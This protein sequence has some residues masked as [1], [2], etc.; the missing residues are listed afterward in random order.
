MFT[1]KDEEQIIQYLKSN[2]TQISGKYL[3]TCLHPSSGRQWAFTKEARG[4]CPPALLYW[5]SYS[6]SLGTVFI[7]PN[8]KFPDRLGGGSGERLQD[9]S[10]QQPRHGIGCCATQISTQ[11]SSFPG[12]LACFITDGHGIK[13]RT[14][15]WESP[16]WGP[17][18]F[19]LLPFLD[20]FCDAAS[21]CASLPASPDS[22]S[23]SVQTPLPPVFKGPLLS[24]W[25]TGSI[26]TFSC[27]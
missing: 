26:T 12:L 24:R 21:S 14:N 1:C 15:P 10:L 23:T 22:G 5:P 7:L 11:D 27:N 18:R 13:L 4:S 20:H 9:C 16:R 2:H 25:V 17:W 8:C 19:S 3:T 6:L